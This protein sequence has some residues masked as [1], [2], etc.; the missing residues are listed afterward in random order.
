MVTLNNI[1]IFNL[2]HH[3]HLVNTT[4]STN[5]FSTSYIIKAGGTIVSL[6]SIRDG[7]PTAGLTGTMI[8]MMFAMITMMISVVLLS[9]L[10][11]GECVEK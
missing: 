8:T 4:L 5:F 11:E 1:V 2:L 3:L 7:Q 10:V 9:T 6:A